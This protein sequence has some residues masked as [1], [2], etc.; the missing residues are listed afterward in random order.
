M[1]SGYGKG[2][3]SYEDYLNLDPANATNAEDKLKQRRIALE[4]RD[5]AAEAE[6]AALANLSDEEREE[7]EQ[8]EA[9]YAQLQGDGPVTDHDDQTSLFTGPAD[10]PVYTRRW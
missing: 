3:A 2:Y 9:Y 5:L 6:A 1:E 10:E 4:G 7:L 8:L